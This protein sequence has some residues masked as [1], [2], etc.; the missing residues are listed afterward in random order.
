[1]SLAVEGFTNLFTN[2]LDYP[3]PTIVKHAKV[4]NSGSARGS[5][6]SRRCDIPDSKSPS[7]Y[8]SS[9]SATVTAFTPSPF[10]KKMIANEKETVESLL[11]VAAKIGPVVNNIVE[12]EKAYDAA[13]EAETP[14]AIPGYGSTLQGFALLLFF[15]SYG[16]L[17]IVI[18]IYINA[19]T[20]NAATAGGTFIG[21]LILAFILMGVIKRYG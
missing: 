4:P 7:A 17:M 18:A 13:F 12:K 3:K 15:V 10:L 14:A 11:K 5:S 19:T 20:G 6:N 21:L 8:V 9:S 2:V 16:A 1:M